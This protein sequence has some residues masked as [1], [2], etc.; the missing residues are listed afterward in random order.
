MAKRKYPNG[1]FQYIRDNKKQNISAN[2]FLKISSAS[3]ESHSV[4]EKYINRTKEISHT[5]MDASSN[6]Y[7]NTESTRTEIPSSAT[8]IITRSKNLT[9]TRTAVFATTELLEEI[10]SNLGPGDLLTIQHVCKS[11]RTVTLTS[12]TLQRALFLTAEVPK[13]FWA[14]CIKTA[15]ITSVPL[16]SRH[17]A[18]RLPTPG[19]KTNEYNLFYP[20]K[21]NSLF[22]HQP[23]PALENKDEEKRNSLMRRAVF[24]ETFTLTSA[25]NLHNLESWNPSPSKVNQMFL[26]QPPATSIIIHIIYGITPAPAKG[27]WALPGQRK[28][29]KYDRHVRAEVKNP[30]GVTWWDLVS[31]F[32]E[33]VR[34][35]EPW[36]DWSRVRVKKEGSRVWMRKMIFPTEGERGVVEGKGHR[37]ERADVADFRRF[38][39][40]AE[41]D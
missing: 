11:F 9:A 35:R 29:I 39:L 22:L 10:L 13:N 14:C 24:C 8:T 15:K 40:E 6:A 28:R 32:S 12:P 2:F 34:E 26:S 23:Q 16:D 1:S 17:T 19:E 20:G 5:T 38:V 37:P 41:G 36:W 7:I 25:F 33:V 27:V 31:A 18:L 3:C 4:S 21:V 30:L